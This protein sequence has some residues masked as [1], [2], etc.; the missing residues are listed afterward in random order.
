MV[1]NLMQKTVW[2]RED[3][4]RKNEPG[5]F[6]M[7]DCKFRLLWNLAVECGGRRTIDVAGGRELSYNKQYPDILGLTIIS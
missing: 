4:I 1:K 5:R 7:V 6:L 2:A 3:G